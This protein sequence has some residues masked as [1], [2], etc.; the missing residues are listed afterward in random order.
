MINYD[1]KPSISPHISKFYI[2]PSHLIEINNN[3]M[4]KTKSTP[5]SKKEH[6]TSH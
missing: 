3:I 1:I 5:P 2:F 6:I 4:S